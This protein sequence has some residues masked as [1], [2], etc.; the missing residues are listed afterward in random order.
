MQAMNYQFDS[1][2]ICEWLN[3]QP[4]EI[5][6]TL[7]FGLIKMDTAGIVLH[8]NKEESAI[9]GILKEKTMGKHFFTQ[10]AP[11]TNNFMV[12]EKYKTEELDE[13]VQYIFT[14]ITRP[15]PVLLR[16]LKNAGGY[17]YMLVKRL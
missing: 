4:D 14:Y 13:Q 6:D 7:S 8:Y 10:I 17:Q 11:C 12:A 9:T 3:T 5:L 16:L 15:I 2:G 1:P